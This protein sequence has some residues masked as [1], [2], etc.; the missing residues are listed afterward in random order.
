MAKRPTQLDKA[1]QNLDDQIAALQLA[2]QHLVQQQR[3]VATKTA[4]KR[5]TGTLVVEKIG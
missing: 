3:T 1:I 4:P 2:R 5:R